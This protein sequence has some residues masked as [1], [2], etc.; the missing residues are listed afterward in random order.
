MEDE[1]AGAPVVEKRKFYY[2]LTFWI[3][4]TWFVAAALTILILIFFGVLPLI[5]KFW[6]KCQSDT[7]VVLLLSGLLF[8]SIAIVLEI[9]LT[10]D[11]RSCGGRRKLV[12]FLAAFGGTLI[13][14]ILAFVCAGRYRVMRGAEHVQAGGCS[15][16]C[17]KVDNP[18][19]NT[20][21]KDD[22]AKDD[23]CGDFIGRRTTRMRDAV[24]YMS[25]VFFVVDFI[26]LVMFLLLTCCKTKKDRRRHGDPHPYTQPEK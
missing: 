17:Q 12:M 13:Y 24:V 8:L 18:E 22:W 4:L 7:P 23:T 26:W 21:L 10:V 9:I 2:S 1:I 5:G 19:W 11:W 25:V 3:K 20:W 14:G 16:V 15:F 6:R